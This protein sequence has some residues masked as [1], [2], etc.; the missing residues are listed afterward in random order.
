VNDRYGHQA[1]DEVLRQVAHR[2][3]G[4][5]RSTDLVARTGG[6]EFVVLAPDIDPEQA[7]ALAQRIR[8][9]VAEPTE[10]EGHIVQ[11]GVTIGVSYADDALTEATLD[12]ADQALVNAKARDR[13][14]VRWAAGTV[15]AAQLPRPPGAEVSS[16]AL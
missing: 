1:G 14:T 4:A 8:S 15:A 5:V 10:V 13:G 3:E 16:S 7:A 6:D 11:V 9:A 12:G 2:I